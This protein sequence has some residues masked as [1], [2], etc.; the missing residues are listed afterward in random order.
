[1]GGLAGFLPGQMEV[2]GSRKEL[3]VKAEQTWAEKLPA[4]GAFIGDEATRDLAKA[5]VR[6]GREWSHP[7][8]LQYESWFQYSCWGT[9][10][11]RDGWEEARNIPS[12]LLQ[13]ITWN[14]YHEATNLS[15]GINTRYAYYDLT[16][17]Y[18]RWWKDG[19]PPQFDH[20]KVYIFSHKYVKGAKIFPFQPRADMDNC[21]EVVSILTKPAHSRAR[22]GV[23]LAGSA[24]DGTKAE[25]DAP[26]GYSFRQLK[27][28]PGPVLVDLLRGGKIEIRL[29][30]PESVS[31]KPFREDVTK[32]CW[33]TEEERNWKAD[34]GDRPMEVYSE[35]GDV[36]HNGL[37]NWFECCGSASSATCRPRAAAPIQTP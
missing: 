24:L 23:R 32:T 37:P 19:I 29:E 8:L 15:P 27:L 35:Y 10:A 31:D 20:D 33:S 30:H 21:I 6:A 18:I 3:F 12:S 36:N 28:T 2:Q 14:D 25:W 5:A 34:F 9:Q 26:A 11:L 1:M 7:I 13:Y 16:G 4:F 22:Q 17:Y